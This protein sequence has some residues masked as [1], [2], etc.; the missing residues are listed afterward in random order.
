MIN[1]NSRLGKLA[2]ALSD[3]LEWQVRSQSW[4]GN[5][6]KAAGVRAKRERPRMPLI[7]SGHGI[8][9]R[10]EGGSLFIRN[11]FTHYPQKQETYRFFKGELTIPHRIIILD[12]SGSISFDVLSWLS[13]QGVS[14]IQI[15][16]RGE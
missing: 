13:E 12:G 14:L 4:S 5:A 16:W 7:L 6:T 3:D 8:S 10:V 15:D 9:Q 1:M 11:G 2:E